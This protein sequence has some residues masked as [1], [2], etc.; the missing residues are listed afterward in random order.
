M[1]D[2][3][4][5]IPVLVRHTDGS[6]AVAMF[7]DA[8]GRLCS[9]QESSAPGKVWLG[10]DIGQILEGGGDDSRKVVLTRMHLTREHVARLLPALTAFV[11]NGSITAHETD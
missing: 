7:E 6:K 8:D 1:G 11:V 4:R 2:T 9:L 10:V 5:D 3:Q